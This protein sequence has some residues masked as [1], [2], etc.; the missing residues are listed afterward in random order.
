MRSRKIKNKSVD[1]VQHQKYYQ[2]FKPTRGGGFG[3]L[4]KN[5]LEVDD[6]NK[7]FM[8]INNTNRSP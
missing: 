7:N 6:L 4:N 5:N 8:T 3:Y 1:R 2:K